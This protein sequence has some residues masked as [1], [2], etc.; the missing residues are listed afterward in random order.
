M[1]FQSLL[2]SSVSYVSTSLITIGLAC[3]SLRTTLDIALSQLLLSF[4]EPIEPEK[5]YGALR[6]LHTC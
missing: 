3:L 1:P 5:H 6:T 2:L 4:T